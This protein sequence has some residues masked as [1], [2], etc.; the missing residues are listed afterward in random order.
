M[1]QGLGYKHVTKITKARQQT[2]DMLNKLSLALEYIPQNQ[3]S[4]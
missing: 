3:L 2:L 4:T 1:N